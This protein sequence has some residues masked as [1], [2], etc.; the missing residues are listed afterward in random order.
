MSV[1]LVLGAT[2]YFFCLL[3]TSVLISL[4]ICNLKVIINLI[5]MIMNTINCKC[6]FHF[7]YT[8]NDFTSFIFMTKMRSKEDVILTA[9]GFRETSTAL[10]TQHCRMVS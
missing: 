1:V 7:I 4:N 6:I 9:V 5:D 3:M 2:I 10:L 8:L